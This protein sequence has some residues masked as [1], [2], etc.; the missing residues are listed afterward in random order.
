MA[1]NYVSCP[2]S[3]GLGGFNEWPFPYAQDL[4][5]D[6][7]CESHPTKKSQDEDDICETLSEDSDENNE[8]RE[9]RNDEHHVC[10]SHQNLVNELPQV[11]SHQTNQKSKAY[12]DD[13]CC[14][15]Y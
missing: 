10:E 11:T 7:P 5:S 14:N 9:P 2:R 13:G 12:S 3:R 8:E 6:E 4:R 15:S 1:N